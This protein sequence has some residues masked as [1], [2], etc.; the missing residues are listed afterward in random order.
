MAENAAVPAV[1]TKAAPVADPKAAVVDPKAAPVA[2]ETTETYLVNGKEVKLTA[3]EARAAVQKGLFAD[4]RLKS[5]DVLTKSSTAIVNALKTPQGVIDLLKDKSLGNSPKAVL[6]ALL[7]SDAIDEEVKEE[8]S[9]WVYKNVVQPAKLSPEEIERDKKLSEYERLK[10]A[11]EDRKQADMTKQQREQVNQV[12]QNVR[13]EVTKQ[14]L[15]DKTFPQTEGS[16]RSVVEK[17]RVMNK[18]GA[19]ITVENVTKALGLVKSDFY[20]HQVAI[21]DAFTDPEDLIKAIGET[22]ALKI[23]KALIA[24]LQ[25]VGKVKPLTQESDA[26]KPRRKIT[27]VLDERNGRHPSGYSLTKF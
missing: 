14:I 25:K 9:A 22:R 8:L 15:A 2:A 13:A 27:D 4:Q 24:R 19:P 26:D 16:I 18:K 10:K 1:G 3:K 6:K 17:L 23:S 7:S 5:M 21:L 20:A 12:Y 11:D